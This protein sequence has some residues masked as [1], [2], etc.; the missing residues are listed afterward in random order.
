L[1]YY[2]F[3]QKKKKKKKKK[4]RPFIKI[5]N[6]KGAPTRLIQRAVSPGNLARL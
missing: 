2:V 1:F 6:K 3:P 5:K 4:N